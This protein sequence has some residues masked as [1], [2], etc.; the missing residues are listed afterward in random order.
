MLIR[1]GEHKLY[2]NNNI[3]QN[4]KTILKRK[5]YTNDH[6]QTSIDGNF[7]EKVN[8]YYVKVGKIAINQKTNVK[9]RI[10]KKAFNT[11]QVEK[12]NTQVY[13]LIV[14][15]YL[16]NQKELINCLQKKHIQIF[17]KFHRKQYSQLDIHIPLLLKT[18]NF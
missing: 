18:K 16:I 15:I 4:N 9:K 13:Y 11:I 17:K 5:E 10:I 1:R 6:V 8:L 3:K 12:I 2:A 7:F 14:Q